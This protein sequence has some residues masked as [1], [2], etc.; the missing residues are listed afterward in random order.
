MG[1]N[2]TKIRL[3]EET[4]RLLQGVGDAADVADAYWVAKKMRQGEPVYSYCGGILVTKEDI[5]ENMCQEI[6]R[7]SFG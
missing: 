2:A 3:S 7:D 1:Q 4:V 5:L 6:P